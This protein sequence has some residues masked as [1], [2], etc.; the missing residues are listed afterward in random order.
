MNTVLKSFIAVCSVLMATELAGRLCSKNAMVKF[1]RALAALAL[2]ASVLTGISPLDWDFSG[3]EQKAE[4]AREELSGYVEDQLEEAAKE[5][6]QSYLSGLLAA[7]GL[8]AEKMELVTDIG[9]NGSIVLTKVKVVF[10][11]ESDAERARALLSQTI[12]EETEVEVQT[13]GR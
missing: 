11:Y 4:Q 5:D 1:V 10:A 6:A 13:N 2:L 3:S 8:E 12:G 9:E 7:A